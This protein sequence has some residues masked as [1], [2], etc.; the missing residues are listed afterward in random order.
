MSYGSVNEG[1]NGKLLSALLRCVLGVAR[2][3][4]CGFML[5]VLSCLGTDTEGG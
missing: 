5:I 3:S 2:C 1:N 4:L